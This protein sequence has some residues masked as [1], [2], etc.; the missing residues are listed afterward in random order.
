[1]IWTQ[2]T[3]T[4][5]I[6]G[7]AK[8]LGT[9][10]GS[11]EISAS[12]T[13]LTVTG[14]V[15]LASILAVDG[16]SVI[17]TQATNTV[18][19][20]GT[21]KILG[22][23]IGSAEISAS[24]TALTVTG[25]VNLA[26][27]LAVDEASVTWNKA[28]DKVGITGTAKILGT[29]IG[30][31]VISASP[32][33]LTVTGNV[34]LASILAVDG[35]S[36]TWNKATNKVGITGTAKILGTSIGSAMI[37]ASPTGLTV[38]GNVNLA[39]ILAVDGASVTWNK[40]KKKVGISGTAKILGT[41]IANA[42]ITASPTDLTVTGSVNLA[43][44]LAVEGASVT[45][46]QATNKVGISG[47]AKILGTEIGSA[48]ISASPTALTVTGNVNLASIL[49][50]DEA[51]VT[52]N[53]AKDK[54]GITGTA[55]ILGTEIG[56][57]EITASKDGLIVKGDVDL[58]PLEIDNATVTWNKWNKASNSVEISGTATLFGQTLSDASFKVGSDG[59]TIEKANLSA[60]ALS[61]GISNVKVSS[62]TKELSGGASVKLNGTSLSNGSFSYN[63]TKGLTAKADLSVSAGDFGKI[64]AEFDMTV[65]SS[66][67]ANLS[68]STPFGS[69]GFSISPNSFSSG[70]IAN[71]V[72]NAIWDI[73]GNLPGYLL[74]LV[75]DGVNSLLNVGSQIIGAASD[76]FDSIVGVF[77]DFLDLFSTDD[78]PVQYAGGSGN[79][80]KD[81]GN[82]KDVLF[83]NVGN[84]SLFGKQGSDQLDGGK[85]ND[86][87]IGGRDKDNL[88]GGDGNDTLFGQKESDTLYGWNGDDYLTGF[89]QSDGEPVDDRA[90][91]LEGGTGKDTLYGDMYAD[92]LKGGGGNDYLDGYDGYDILEG[93]DGNDRL[94][95]DTGNDY[96]SGDTG[97]DT[98]IGGSGNDI[99]VGGSGADQFE[100]GDPAGIYY[101]I[102][103]DFNRVEDKKIY[104]NYGSTEKSKFSFNYTTDILSFNGVTIV[105]L[106]GIANTS[107][108][109]VIS[110]IGFY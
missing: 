64:G 50:V 4:V 67:S 45:W 95:G 31:A 6:T 71:D 26:S 100:F 44:I 29:E 11:A 93:N 33:A 90:N 79:D 18:G 34:N 75:K 110:D 108:F 46:T 9:T 57:A 1:V 107:Q 80:S 69:L 51:S 59:I 48:E 96:V 61:L 73:V 84:D 22:T 82:N 98:L 5:G 30:S 23:E 99:L 97:N 53:K 7:T 47:T 35:A 28:K 25:N 89:G 78:D 56:S 36:V 83:G 20:T 62:K 40:A 70:S 43:S 105:Q 24:P 63:T 94:W 52:W 21:A 55:K 19:I 101:D 106:E 17:W 37:S 41:S 27:I 88:F 14:N 72:I 15:N 68:A 104:F 74:D 102:I 32:T 42:A 13:A 76:V 58:G 38:T 109:S 103:K 91:L 10:I 92:T 77:D 2:A 12:P 60:G 66:L 65:G 85:G 16:A 54:V 49:A 86:R 8:I 39:S 87:L 3:N 81:G